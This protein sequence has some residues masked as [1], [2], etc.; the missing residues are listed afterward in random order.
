MFMRGR[1]RY[2]HEQLLKNSPVGASETPFG[3]PSGRVRG[4]ILRNSE[5][6]D[7]NCSLKSPPLDFFHQAGA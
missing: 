4:V 2:R 5:H 3:P 7:Q 1:V 6:S